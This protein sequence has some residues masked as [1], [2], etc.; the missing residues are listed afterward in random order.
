MRRRTRYSLLLALAIIAALVVA[1]LLRKAAPPEV[2]R[3]LPESDAIFYANLRPI[4]LATHFDRAQIHRSPEY[5]QFIDA[6]GIV[7]ERDLDAVAFAVHRM[8]DPNGPNGP[9]GY[10]EVFEGRF[11]GV[12]LG[13]Y[14]RSL[15]TSIEDYDGHTIYT[16]PVG[17][18]KDIRPFRITQLAYDTIAASNMPTTEQIHS[19]LDRHRAAASPF[20]GSSLLRARYRDVPLLSPVWAI[21]HIGLPFSDRGYISVFGLQLPLAADTT[22]VASLRYVGALHLRIV[23]YAPNETTAAN[24]T[25]T[26]NT[27]LNLFRSIQ[28]NQPTNPNDAALL[29]MT[30]TI[31][32]EQ[33]K[34]HAVLSANV[35]IELIKQLT[36]APPSPQP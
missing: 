15:A 28:Q 12:R 6:T 16:I 25:Q 9:V 1:V 32:I 23:E 4:R 7:P 33:D 5:Q 26:L 36:A 29:Q 21:G 18:G 34:D 27:L 19:I 14:L 2:A 22:F 20:A 13:R 17:E 3:L 11:D 10:S 24:T 30:N 31:K 35:P 8:P